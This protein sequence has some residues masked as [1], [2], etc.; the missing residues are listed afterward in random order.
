[1]TDLTPEEL[2]EIIA[3]Y[4]YNSVQDRYRIE[5]LTVENIELRKELDKLKSTYQNKVVDSPKQP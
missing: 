1:M 4:R 2:A 5:R 3:R